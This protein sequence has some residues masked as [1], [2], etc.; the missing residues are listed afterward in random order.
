MERSNDAE[1]PGGSRGLEHRWTPARRAS[2]GWQALRA[3]PTDAAAAHHARAVALRDDGQPAR[4]RRA[5]Q[6]ALRLFERHAGP[7]HPDVANVALELALADEDLARYASAL[8]LVRR[9]LA[10]LAPLRGARE[11]RLQALGQLGQ[12]HIARGEYG[13]AE[14]AYRRAL[15]IASRGQVPAATAAALTGLGVVCKYTARHDEASAFYRKALAMTV[16]G[17][18]RDDPGVATILHNLGGLEH[19]RGRF[20]RGE[21][22]ARRSVAIRER[23]LGP[24]HPHVAADQAALAA[25]LAGRGKHREAEALYR[26]AIAVYRRA[27][28]RD[29]WEVGF[30][31]GQLAALY[32][33]EGRLG[34]AGRVYGRA[35][36]QLSRTTDRRNPLLAM[37]LW[38]AATLRR[39][40]GRRDAAEALF[41]TALAIFRRTV[42][43]THPD[44]VACA[45]DRKR[46]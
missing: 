17:R 41:R 39:Q 28:G 26:R 27:L 44:A 31:L 37:V 45:A 46:R 40:Q 36:R 4:A 24:D 29:H 15:A 6:V 35:V 8:R 21:P 22:F 3:D 10:I 23:A 20:A 34:D 14:A 18:G 9:A 33:A 5:C 1:E 11:L 13:A 42:G 7:R 30:N 19:A 16:R 2:I 25:I 38:N 43:P 32:Q 12:L